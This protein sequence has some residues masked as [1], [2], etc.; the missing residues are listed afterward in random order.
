V[1]ENP[2]PSAGE[3][4]LARSE[5]GER[6]RKKVLRD[7]AKTMRRS[8]T[9]AEQRL[10]KILRSKRLSGYKFKRQLPIDH[11]IADFVCLSHRL[12]IEADGGQHAESTRDQR[13][14]AYLRSQHFRILRLWNSDIMDN[15]TGIYDAI[16]NALE[17]PLP[18]PSP[19]K[20]RGAI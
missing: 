8:Q 15:E 14:D 1:P 16:L 20:G 18:N 11:Y 4:R 3:G 17:A 10:W 5:S 13:R 6:E 9:P 7:R 19:A 2:L 12:I